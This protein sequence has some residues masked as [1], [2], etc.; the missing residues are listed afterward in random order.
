[1]QVLSWG[2]KLLSS[3]LLLA[4]A[5]C[6]YGALAGDLLSV[7]LKAARLSVAGAG[8]VAAWWVHTSSKHLLPS[9]FP[10]STSRATAPGAGA[11]GFMS[12]SEER[13]FS[14]QASLLLLLLFLLL[15]LLLL[16]S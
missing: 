12:A 16:R 1:M 15:L 9:S 14:K 11:G 10:A 5:C 8:V 2:T 4:A 6:A 13:D 7:P 3:T